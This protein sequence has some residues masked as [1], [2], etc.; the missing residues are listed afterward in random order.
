M[1]SCPLVEL[2]KSTRQALRRNVVFVIVAAVSIEEFL[3][4]CFFQVTT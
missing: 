2:C 4:F 3:I 1:N